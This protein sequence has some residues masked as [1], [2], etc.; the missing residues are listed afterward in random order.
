MTIC[1]CISHAYAC[2]NK[3][4]EESVKQSLL[5]VIL[6]YFLVQN[7]DRSSSFQKSAFVLTQRVTECVHKNYDPTHM[8]VK[9][10]AVC[11]SALNTLW[12]DILH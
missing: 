2:E 7:T 9:V 6:F 3:K 4:N 11:Y 5:C 8:A 10:L 12:C 1:I